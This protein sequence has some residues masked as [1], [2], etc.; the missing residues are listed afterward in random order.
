MA[1]PVSLANQF[2]E[3]PVLTADS[4]RAIVG[5]ENLHLL[6]VTP[7]AVHGFSKY[8][9]RRGFVRTSLVFAGLGLLAGCEAPFGLIGRPQRH[10]RIGYLSEN[11]EAA[12]APNLAALRQGLSELGYVAGQNV[13]FEVRYAKGSEKPLPALAAELVGLNLDLIVPASDAAIRAAMLSTSTIPIVFA[14]SGDPVVNGHVASLARPGGNATGLSGNTGQ[15]TAKR[16]ELLKEAVPGVSNVAV[17]WDPFDEPSFR[18]AE[19]AAQI[20]GVQILSLEL[21]DSENLDDVLGTAIGHADGLAP[22]GGPSFLPLAPRIVAFAATYA[23]PA[24]YTSSTYVAPGGLMMYGQNIQALFKR[25][26]TYVDK[27]LKGAKPADLPVEQPKTFDFVINLRT[28]KALG[29]SIP[30]LVLMQATEVI[31]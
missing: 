4:Y 24:I 12:T 11:T 3:C 18:Q 31:Q 15:E 28:A 7:R 30:Q 13:T 17:L 1:R 2:D 9:S 21:Q 22:L 6:M 23:L 8:L 5:R 26:A 29:L 20:L 10:Y 25:A 14:T 16:L 27:I 19:A